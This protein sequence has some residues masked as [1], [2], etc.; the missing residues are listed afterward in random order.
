MNK[1]SRLYINQEIKKDDIIILVEDNYHYLKSVLRAKKGEYLNIFNNKEEYKAQIEEISKKDMT[2][3]VKKKE[4]E[5]YKKT[6]LKVIS[7]PIKLNNLKTMV[8]KLAELGVEELILTN[9]ERTT[10]KKVN[11]DKLKEISKHATQQ[12]KNFKPMTIKYIENINNIPFEQ[13][14]TVYLADE[15]QKDIKIELNNNNYILIVGPEGGFT[16]TER[17]Y[18]INELQ[19]TSISLS[20]SILRT[21]TA[22]ICGSYTIINQ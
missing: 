13:N 19:A 11:I 3:R 18:I 2:L 14:E 9:F 21:E 8:Q 12:S 4:K 22:A 1:D 7:S 6:K 17:L 10:M 20:K 5:A 16:K 15:T